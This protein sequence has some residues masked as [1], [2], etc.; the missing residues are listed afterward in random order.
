MYPRS[1]CQYGYIDS[2]ESHDCCIPPVTLVRIE[3]SFR[4]NPGNVQSNHNKTVQ[5]NANPHSD[6]KD[7][8]TL[9][10]HDNRQGHK[11]INQWRLRNGTMETKCDSS[12]T[13][14]TS[15]A[16]KINLV[17]TLRSVQTQI[18]LSPGLGPAVFADG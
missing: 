15:I 13:T 16:L 14:Y 5:V 9:P 12:R 3:S 4:D 17:H 6:S 2:L 8:I 11:K 10:V 7:S 18:H 1:T